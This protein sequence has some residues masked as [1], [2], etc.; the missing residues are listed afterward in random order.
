MI[1]ERD[2]SGKR[3][4]EADMFCVVRDKLTALRRLARYLPETL[5]TN[6][7]ILLGT[8]DS[9]AGNVVVEVI[10]RTVQLLELL[11]SIELV[12]E[13]LPHGT[14]ML[15]MIA[16]QSTDYSHCKLRTKSSMPSLHKGVPARE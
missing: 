7:E 1:D 3:R 4:T 12:F 11:V 14:G 10:H 9:V 6:F 15:R 2:V 16:D 8:I 5:L 13:N